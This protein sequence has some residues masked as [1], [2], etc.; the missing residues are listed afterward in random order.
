[1]KITVKTTVAAPI[2]KVWKAYTTPADIVQWNAASADWHTTKASVDLREGGAFS[3]R[4][5]AKDGS[6]GFDFA[7]TYTKITPHKLIEYSFGDRKAQVKFTPGAKGAKGVEVKVTFDAES[8]NSPEKQ[9]GGWQAILDNFARH[10]A[11][12]AGGASAPDKK[13]K[14]AGTPQ[15]NTVRLHRVLPVKPEKV[16]RAFTNAEAMAQW[17]PPNGFTASVH[18]LEAKVGG[19]HRMSFTN[20]TTGNAHAFGGTYLEL[21]PNERLRYTDKFDD[22]N[23]PG[24]M[25]VTVTLKAVSVGTEISI[26]QEGI[27]TVI[28]L[29]GCYLGWQQSLHKLAMLVEPE[30]P[31]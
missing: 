12:G 8:E 15:G 30:I 11:E 10:V 7:G 19:T 26:T 1:M 21:V 2:E 16:Y 25:V 17:L 9:Q 29:E 13:S 6:V 24:E 22:P 14:P 31:G 3:S 18:H 4:M 5:E 27:P 28:P 23:L 20:F